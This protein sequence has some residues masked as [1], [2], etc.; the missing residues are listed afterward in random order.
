MI[1]VMATF[2]TIMR[3]ITVMS[4]W[5]KTVPGSYFQSECCIGG[6][7]V[8]ASRLNLFLAPMHTK[9]KAG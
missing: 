5:K 8:A 3:Q 7:S 6:T 9:H 1:T 4:Q 2:N